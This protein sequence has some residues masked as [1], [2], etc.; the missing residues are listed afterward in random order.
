MFS[1]LAHG[2]GNLK[3]KINLFVAI[4]PITNLGLATQ[5][6]IRDSAEDYGIWKAGLESMKIY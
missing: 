2:H 1:A 6:F 5:H 4:A 3:D